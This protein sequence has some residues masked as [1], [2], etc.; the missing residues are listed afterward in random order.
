MPVNA[1]VQG[2][3]PVS[4]FIFGLIF[5]GLAVG[6]M[7]TGET[8]ARFG[9]VIY[10]AKEPEEFWEEIVAS[11]LCGILLTWSYAYNVPADFLI[12]VTFI[13]VFVHIVYLLSRW[14]IRQKR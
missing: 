4:W 9:R 13:G 6:G 12:T 1:P 5:L 11:F 2:S 14:V 3:G 10:R 7:L 8:L